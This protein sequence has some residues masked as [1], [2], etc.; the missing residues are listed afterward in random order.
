MATTRVYGI[1]L[2]QRDAADAAT[3]Y[4][5]DVLFQGMEAFLSTQLLTPGSHAYIFDPSDQVIAQSGRRAADAASDARNEALAEKV[6]AGLSSVSQAHAAVQTSKFS[7]DGDNYVGTVTQ[8]S[9]SRVLEGGYIASITPI[10]ELT[11]ASDRLLTEGLAVSFFVLAVGVAFAV[12]V[13][14][15]IGRLLGNITDQADRMR[16]FDLEPVA[17][18]KS[19]VSEIAELAAAVG[20]ARRTISA[21]SLYVPREI[22]RRIIASSE[23]AGR[24]GDRQTVT[25]LFSDI[26]D[27]TT[28]CERY[29]AEQVVSMLSQYFDLFSRVIERHHGVI[30]Q[31]SGDGVFAL[32]NTPQPDEQHRDHACRCAL[33]L[34]SALD[35]FNE[36]RRR[37]GAPRVHQTIWGP[38][39]KCDRRQRWRGRSSAIHRDGRCD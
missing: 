30:V 10:A 13:A 24:S 27:F 31:F 20:A 19:R 2:A 33:E 7:H 34:K 4:G 9:G 29:P 26:R 6:R 23:F 16:E 1:T 32:W 14:N 15:R 37:V 36:Q 39:R 18:V 5:I 38:Y 25:A 22:V 17:D 11:R 28:I 8:I 21:F 35:A 3:V 12:F